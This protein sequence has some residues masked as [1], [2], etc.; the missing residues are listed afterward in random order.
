M[1]P[2]DDARTPLDEL[3]TGDSEDQHRE[4]IVGSQTIFP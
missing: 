3:V 4:K 2:I 1:P